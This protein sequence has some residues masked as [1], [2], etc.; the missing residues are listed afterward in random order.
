MNAS[1]NPTQ[2]DILRLMF[3]QDGLRFS[4]INTAKLPTDQFSYHLRQLMKAKLIE[5]LHDETYRLTYI[6]K[7]QTIMLPSESTKIIQQ[8]FVAVLLIVSQQKEGQELF[9]AHQRNK[10]PNKGNIGF[11]GDKVRYGED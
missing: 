11:F 5:K 8:G 7:K 4:E 9:L 2:A 10:V 3:E 6:G 1:L